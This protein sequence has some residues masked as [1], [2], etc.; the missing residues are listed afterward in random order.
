MSATDET[1]KKNLLT[2]RIHVFGR[3]GPLWLQVCIFVENVEISEH[4]YPMDNTVIATAL[5]WEE[6]HATERRMRRE[7]LN[8]DPMKAQAEVSPFPL[9][10]QYRQLSA[11]YPDRMIQEFEREYEVAIR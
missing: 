4:L 6:I 1:L 9:Y 10:A 11:H 5:E 7:L 3:N 8:M 2:H